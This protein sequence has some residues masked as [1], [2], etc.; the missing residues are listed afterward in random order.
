MSDAETRRI[1]IKV[2]KMVKPL[3]RKAAINM[4]APVPKT[5][6]GRKGEE[7]KAGG[8]TVVPVQTSDPTRRGSKDPPREG[9]TARPL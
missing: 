4:D 9:A 7:P 6:T 8:R 3:P 2:E 1:E 5:D